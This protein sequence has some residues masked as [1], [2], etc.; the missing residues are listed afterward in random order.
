MGTRHRL[1]F[2]PDGTF[3]LR[4]KSAPKS[5]HA[6]MTLKQKLPVTKRVKELF[7]VRTRINLA[8]KIRDLLMKKI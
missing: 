3:E 2:V 8:K 4:K 5:Q 7:E 6:T 1:V